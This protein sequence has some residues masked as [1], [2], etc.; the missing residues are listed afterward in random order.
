MAFRAEKFSG[1]HYKFIT[2]ELAIQSK[3]SAWSAVNFKIQKHEN[4][5]APSPPSLSFF[6]PD[7]PNIF[8]RQLRRL[9]ASD[10]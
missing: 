1:L 5:R 2:H 3:T 6:F 8:M 4:K 9:Q 10:N 7:F